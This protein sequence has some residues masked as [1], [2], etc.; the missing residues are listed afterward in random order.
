MYCVVSFCFWA[1][2]PPEEL[3]DRWSSDA[4]LCSQFYSEW[5]FGYSLKNYRTD[6]HIFF[7]TPLFFGL[8][9]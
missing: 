7:Q 3:V 1:G 2:F 4:F 5:L 9:N 8:L 6:W